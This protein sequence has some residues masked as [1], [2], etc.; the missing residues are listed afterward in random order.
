MGGLVGM[1]GRAVG[2]VLGWARATGTMGAWSE[3]A[4]AG[5]ATEAVEAG[6]CL[7]RVGAISPLARSSHM[8]ARRAPSS[9]ADGNLGTDDGIANGICVCLII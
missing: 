1:W 6:L 8:P 5:G 9:P 7:G 4:G 3:R 2:A